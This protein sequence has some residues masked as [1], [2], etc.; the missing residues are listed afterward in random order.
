MT[1][2]QQ[3]HWRYLLGVLPDIETQ[4]LEERLLA[5]PDALQAVE[6]AETDLIDAFVRRKLGPDEQRQFARR[7]L[8]TERGRARV[9]FARALQ[10]KSA[11]AREQAQAAAPAPLGGWGR[12]RCTLARW[13]LRPLGRG[14]V[15]TGALAAAALLLLPF[16]RG[17]RAEAQLELVA[18]Q[19]RGNGRLPTLVLSPDVAVVRLRLPPTEGARDAR[20][21][22]EIRDPRGEI[23]WRNEAWPLA[24]EL[25][26]PARIFGIDGLCELRLIGARA[27]G[28]RED[29]AVYSFRI[30]RADPSR[31]A[32]R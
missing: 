12:I 10:S 23:I 19:V 13:W 31:R 17:P 18:T 1:S 8:T 25:K 20:Y 27:D 11:A 32:R 21:A 3:D 5:D 14:L 30:E 2:G 6:Q 7:Y 22:A 16:V 24:R 28:S 29:A 15:A 9:A 4:A 26:L